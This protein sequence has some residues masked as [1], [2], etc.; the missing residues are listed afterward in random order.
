MMTQSVEMRQRI[1]SLFTFLENVVSSK[2]EMKHRGKRLLIT[3]RIISPVLRFLLSSF[4][5]SCIQLL[6]QNKKLFNSDKDFNVR[7][8]RFEYFTIK[9]KTY[10]KW[11][12]GEFCK[13]LN[14]TLQ[15]LYP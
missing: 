15:V 14:E 5:R 9:T 10:G 13:V 1:L 12:E 11:F 6:C 2:Y 3:V 8:S 7:G 4:R